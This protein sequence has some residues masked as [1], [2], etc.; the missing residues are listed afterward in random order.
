MTTF[1]K[2]ATK[3][4]AYDPAVPVDMLI[5]H[6][7]NP[8]QGNVEAITESIKANGFYGT[9]VAQG[10][11]GH[12]LGGNHRLKA[13]RELGM[14]T[15]PVAWLD[16]DDDRALR[17]LLADNRT[18]DLAEYDD[19]ALSALLQELAESDGLDG[20]GYDDDALGALMAKL[21]DP[22][23]GPDAQIDQAAELQEKW[24]VERGQVWA[25]GNHRLGCGDATNAE[26]VKQLLDGNKPNLMITDPPYGVEYDPAWRNEAAEKGQLAYAARRV[27]EVQNDDRADWSAAWKLSPSDVAY[28]WHGALMVA[29]VLQSLI[30]TKYEPRPQIIWAKSNFP[31][32]RGHYTWTH[33][34]CWYVVRKGATASWIGPATSR[35][36]WSD[37]TLDANVDGGHSTQKPVECMARPMRNHK[38]DVYD[39]FLG[40]GTTMVAAEQLGRTC[41]GIE[42]HP[43][44]CAVIL[45]RMADMGIEGKLA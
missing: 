4:P 44:Y 16:I 17:I 5:T 10:S 29:D 31:I 37:I 19:A 14:E 33:E 22:V 12:V 18:A 6:P 3:T 21:A 26:D 36:V 7:R 8:R 35:T 27:G 28:V 23:E 13:A 25:I 34:P 45:E 15:V 39:P 11:T 9:I 2:K 41:F 30:D 32:S 43:P 40:S 42:L 38:G 24:K 20:T 1:K